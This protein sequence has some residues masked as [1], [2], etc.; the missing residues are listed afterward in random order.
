M[1]ASTPINLDAPG[2][3]VS[4]HFVRGRNVLMARATFT[5][6]YVDYFLHLSAHQV[7]P[8]EAH[9]EMFKRA[10][11]AFV[12]HCATRP[13]KEMT[14]WTINFQRPLVNLFLTA[15]N[16]TGAVA[17]RVLA[18]N[19]RE[20]SANVF[21]ADV[22]RSGQ[23]PRRSAV[24]FE[25]AD[26]LLA[27]AAF[28]EQSEQRGVRFLEPGEEEFALLIEHPDCDTA[29]LRDLT[30]EAFLRLDETE[31]VVP[32][33]RRVYRWHCGCNQARMMD[34]L[35]PVMRSDPEGL[36]GGEETVQI[37]CPRCAA[38]HTLTREAL[39]AHVASNDAAPKRGGGEE[40]G[41]P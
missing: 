33:E 1:S 6:L 14:A 24:N 3:E 2:L 28:Y 17:G 26:P 34:V 21:Y 13:W 30:P 38:R 40:A 12:L 31:T 5:D 10:L 19:V 25:G 41:N 9:A 15:D 23:P 36:F 8:E 29:W 22:V 4:T 39:E 32:M 16:E 18:D 11:A 7:R 20:L 27:A 35:A 37:H